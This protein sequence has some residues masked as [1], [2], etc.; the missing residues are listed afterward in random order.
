MKTRILSCLALTIIPLRAAWSPDRA[1]TVS[2]GNQTN[3]EAAPVFPRGLAI[4]A[5]A[6]KIY[7][8]DD[9]GSRVL[10]YP[11]SAAT[12]NGGAPEAVLGQADFISTGSGNGPSRLSSPSD[13]AVFN[14]SLWVS[15]YGNNRVLRFDNAATK[16]TGSAADAVLGQQNLTVFAAGHARA[17]MSHP[18]GLAVDAAGRLYVADTSNNRVLRFDNAQSLASGAQANVVFGQV[19]YTQFVTGTSASGLNA[20]TDLTIVDQNGGNTTLWVADTGNYR[21]LRYDNAQSASTGDS[22]VGVLGQ[23]G[24]GASGAPPASTDATHFRPSSVAVDTQGRLYAGDTV[25]HRVL[26]F[27]V[28]T[29]SSTTSAL[30]GTPAS[31]SVVLGQPNLSTGT[32]PDASLAA[33]NYEPT[34]LFCEPGGQ[35]WISDAMHHR[36]GCI[37]T[38]LSTDDFILSVGAVPQY[39]G[40][41]FSDAS[42]I[43]VDPVTGKVYV[44][45]QVTNQIF[46]FASYDALTSG[47]AAESRHTNGYAPKALHIDSN[48]KLFC[49]YG[50]SVWVNPT[51]GTTLASFTKIVGE[52]AVAGCSSTLLNNPSAIYC[53]STFIIYVAD[54]GNNR[55]VRFVGDLSGMA[56]YNHSIVLGQTDFDSFA[57]GAGSTKLNGPAGLTEDDNGVL[58]IA[59]TGNARLVAINSIGTK[60]SSGLTFDGVRGQTSL[61]VA[62]TTG[63]AAAN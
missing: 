40:S 46:R 28:A 50:H 39:N 30:N 1:G 56:N 22:A 21:I 5:A 54:T 51:P 36:A 11:V 58:W 37:T 59:D 24:F 17:E 52:G 15:D 42:A 32:A 16:P 10:R 2:L 20:P 49:I 61:F 7:V 3:A 8:L 63:T 41:R 9:G 45:D 19:G 55:V 23:P 38:P 14:G 53:D 12:A 57:A 18:W 62:P 4:D 60:V 34:G 27:N 47:L 26:R 44:A 6:G 33:D 25:G 29:A 35:L 13:V 31:A 43:A 48:G